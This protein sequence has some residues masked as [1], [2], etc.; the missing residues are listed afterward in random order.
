MSLTVQT[1]GEKI[2]D[3][4]LRSRM[5]ERRDGGIWN[6]DPHPRQAARPCVCDTLPCQGEAKMELEAQEGP[7]RLGASLELARHSGNNHLNEVK[8]EAIENQKRE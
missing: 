6:F 1:G 3:S 7:S 4:S 5:T 8:V 2:R